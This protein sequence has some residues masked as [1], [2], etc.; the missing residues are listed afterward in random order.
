MNTAIATLSMYDW[1]ETADALDRFWKQISA[2]I[3]QIG[4]NAPDDLHHVESQVPLWTNPDLL[5][6][7]TCGWPYANK[8]RGKVVPFARFDYGLEDCPPG[9]YQSIYIGRSE[10]DAK[11]IKSRA[12]LAE[13]QS[14][15]VNGDDS[16]SGFHVFGEIGNTSA[17]NCLPAKK[18]VI[19]GA[20]RNSIKYVAEGRAQIAA[21]DAVAFEL[22]R[23]Y[24]AETVAGVTAIG[25]SE[26]KPGL[27]LITS[28][29]YASRI[30]ELF[31]AVSG[32]LQ[33][34]DHETRD[35]L[36]IRNVVPAG[37]EEYEVFLTD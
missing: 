16:Q 2:Y 8:L 37:D 36:M 19:S 14:V 23:Q 12:G 17:A 20:H 13:V 4:I 15:A 28:H 11:F 35:T 9:M 18:R 25:K 34:L 26:P 3:K 6:G 24:D 22:A 1:P 30:D 10:D 21:I 27:P 33:T 32:A 31:A 7:Q 29:Q 5:V